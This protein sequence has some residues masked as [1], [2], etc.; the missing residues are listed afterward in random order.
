MRLCC[1][2]SLIRFNRNM[3]KAFSNESAD[4]PD[5]LAEPPPLPPGIKNYMTP[6][7]ARHLQEERDRLLTE[8][9]ALRPDDFEGQRRLSWIERRLRFLA[10]RLESA[11]II[12]PAKQPTDR[13]LFGAEVTLTDAQGG[14]QTWRIVGFDEADL[15]RGRVSWMAPLAGA[16]LQAKLGDT[17]SFQKERW[18]ISK[19]SYPI[20]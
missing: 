8:R 10:S 3:S 20:D 6:A 12:D 16:L 2:G 7:G 1:K 14:L 17:V 11:Q 18:T 19:I 15:H 13:V 9:K 4:E 5:T